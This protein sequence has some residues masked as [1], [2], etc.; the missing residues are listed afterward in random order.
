MII[1]N[2]DELSKFVAELRDAM[3]VQQGQHSAVQPLTTQEM[4]SDHYALRRRRESEFDADLFSDPAWDILLDL[5]LAARAQ[6]R[7]SVTSACIASAAPATTALRW[8]EVL[9]NRGLIVRAPDPADRRRTFVDLA[10]G[11]AA[12][13]ECVF[14]RTP[15]GT[16][17][18]AVVN[19][20]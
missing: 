1:N 13:I 3:P 5:Y 8:I 11:V 15:D 14:G 18:L 6:K 4:V 10:P 16:A 19:G 20:L 7:I 2:I 9:A 12:R 17:R